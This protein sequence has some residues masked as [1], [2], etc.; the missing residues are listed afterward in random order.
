MDFTGVAKFVQQHFADG[1]CVIVGSGLSSA[2]G[3][4]GM[5]QL[6]DHLNTHSEALSGDDA[7]TWSKISAMLAAKSGLEAA[8]L[9]HQPSQALEEWIRRRT[10]ELLLPHEKAVIAKA[11]RGD[12]TLRLTTFVRKIRIPGGGLP[13]VTPNYDRLIEVACEMGGLHCDTTAVGQ[14]AGQFDHKRSVMASCKRIIQ[15]AKSAILEHFPR[16]AILKPHGSF[17]WYRGKD[18]PFRSSLDLDID[19]LIITPGLN[20]YRAGYDSPFDRHREIGNQHICTA[21]RLLVIAYG[22][23]DDHLQTHLVKR[24]QEGIPTLIVSHSISPN[25]LKLVDDSPACV[26]FTARPGSKVGTVIRSK[27]ETLDQDGG[28]LWDL[29]VLTTELLS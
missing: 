21:T 19:R 4:P 28:N 3:I 16:A 8:L 17:D 26:C 7:A 15:H 12:I 13:F 29:G 25:V 6:A 14:Y 22:F 27:R 18:G 9:A 20:K 5:G 23:N 11:I 10:C 1:L 2:E 24:I